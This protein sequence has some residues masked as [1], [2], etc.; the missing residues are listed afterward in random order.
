[1]DQWTTVLCFTL[2]H[3]AHLA[4]ALLGSY[5]I[6][7]MLLDELTVQTDNFISNAVG[8]IKLQVKDSH[9]KLALT[10]LEEGGYINHSAHKKIEI[11]KLPAQGNTTQCPYC[12]SLNIAQN[13]APNRLSIFLIIITGALIPIFK[14]HYHCF[15]CDKDWKFKIEK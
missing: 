6:D 13:K 10:V 9:V 5:D 12:Q 15:D 3:E 11:F 7:V 1:M 2:P 4:K 14:K 8:G